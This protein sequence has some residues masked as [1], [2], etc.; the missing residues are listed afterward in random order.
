MWKA[1]ACRLSQITGS[2]FWRMVVKMPDMTGWIS[3]G[4]YYFVRAC[5]IVHF[6]VG[7]KRRYHLGAFDEAKVTEGLFSRTCHIAE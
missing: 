6:E 1:I 2:D 4:R 5:D 7:T 3:W